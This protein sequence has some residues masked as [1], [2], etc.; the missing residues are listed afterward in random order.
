MATH[1]APQHRPP[2]RIAD[3]LFLV[4][5]S[6]I[7]GAGWLVGG[8]TP[9]LLQDLPALPVLALLLGG[10]CLPILVAH[11]RQH[12]N[13]TAIAILTLLLGWTILGWIIALVW[14]CTAVRPALQAPRA[15]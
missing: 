4:V 8:D 9:G 1:S 13:K 12:H 15:S 11:R 14:A 2:A 7:V 10:L 5:L 3:T 6:G